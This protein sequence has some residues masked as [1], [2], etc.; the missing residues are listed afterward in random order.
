M[1]YVCNIMVITCDQLVKI[2]NLL[3]YMDRLTNYLLKLKVESEPHRSDKWTGSYKEISYFNCAHFIQL[4]SFI[5][6]F[7]FLCFS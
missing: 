5:Q 7:F 6:A 1:Q 3:L 2:T 4:A